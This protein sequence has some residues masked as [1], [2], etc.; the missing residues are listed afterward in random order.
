MVRDCSSEDAVLFWEDTG[1]G[2]TFLQW[3]L[4]FHQ[5]PGGAQ[6]PK[7]LIGL[8]RAQFLFAGGRSEVQR[9]GGSP[10]PEAGLLPP[11]PELDIPLP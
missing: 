5:L 1:R 2:G 4:T 9:E 11:G 7:R 10:S 6:N 3:V 8:P